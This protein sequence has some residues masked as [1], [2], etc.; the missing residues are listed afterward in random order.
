MGE[1]YIISTLVENKPGVLYR[2]SNMFRRRNFNIDSITVGPTEIKDLA[3]MTITINGD[4]ALVEQV[5]KQLGKL[6]D[7]IKVSVLN[8]KSTVTRELALVKLHATD[9]KVRADIINYSNVFRGRIVDVSPDSMMVEV[10]GTPDKIDAFIHIANSYGIKEIAR[11]GLT[12][13]QRG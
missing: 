8:S 6:M 5:V 3:R 13:L 1:N 7:V 12:A 9:A 11:T 4:R 2:A 10:T